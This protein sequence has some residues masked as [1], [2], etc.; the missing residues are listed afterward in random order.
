MVGE[1]SIVLSQLLSHRGWSKKSS[2]SRIILTFNI[3]PLL[4]LYKISTK[5]TVGLINTTILLQK[6]VGATT[7]LITTAQK[8]MLVLTESTSE[9]EKIR[10]LQIQLVKMRSLQ[11]VEVASNPVWL[12]ALCKKEHIKRHRENTLEQAGEAG[13]GCHKWKSH[14]GLPEAEE[15]RVSKLQKHYSKHLGLTLLASRTQ[16]ISAVLSNLVYGIV[17]A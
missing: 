5:Y 7:G 8:G 14:L 13:V 3:L 15:E 6:Y 17:T 2:V 11:E 9:C 1:L 12:V 4:H 10:S 16:Y